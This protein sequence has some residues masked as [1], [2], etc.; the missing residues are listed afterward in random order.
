MTNFPHHLTTTKTN[1]HIAH[2]NTQTDKYYNE[3]TDNINI[4]KLLLLTLTQIK[5]FTNKQININCYQNP[6]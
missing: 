1:K 5:A 3:R 4:T 6:Q 2:T